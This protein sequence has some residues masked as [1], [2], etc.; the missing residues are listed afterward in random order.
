MIQNTFLDTENSKLQQR[1]S[2]L[3]T[4]SQKYR[5]TFGQHSAESVLLESRKSKGSDQNKI[6]DKKNG[7]MIPCWLWRFE[8]FSMIVE[9]ESATFFLLKNGYKIEYK[10]YTVCIEYCGENVG[11][12]ANY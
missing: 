9:I 8:D 6:A 4:V 1:F 10:D 5:I 7:K 3:L 2:S 11:C 12:H